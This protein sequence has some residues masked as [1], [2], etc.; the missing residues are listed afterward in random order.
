VVGQEAS[1]GSNVEAVSLEL[2]TGDPGRINCMCQGPG[3][4]ETRVATSVMGEDTL[5]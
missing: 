4:L 1:W 2:E 5:S 3:H